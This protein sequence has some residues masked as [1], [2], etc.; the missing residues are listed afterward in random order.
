MRAHMARDQ[1]IA[2]GGRARRSEGPDSTAG[3]ANIL[4]H[5]LL[6]EVAR[7][8]VGN[9]PPG[10]V[11]WPAGSEGHNH[12]DCFCRIVLRHCPADSCNQGKQSRDRSFSHRPLPLNLQ[13]FM[14]ETIPCCGTEYTRTILS[15]RGATSGPVIGVRRIGT[16]FFTNLS[17]VASGS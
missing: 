2:V 16:S 10:D 7:E 12:G 3:A 6:T 1:R 9:D 8:D 4:H 17:T 13:V 5:E 11:G 14:G 15:H